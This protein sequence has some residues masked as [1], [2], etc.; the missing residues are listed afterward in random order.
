MKKRVAI[1]L[2]A[3]CMTVFC[4]GCESK[5]PYDD[6]Y[7]SDEKIAMEDQFEAQKEED[8]K[9][10]DG[11]YQYTADA[12][13]GAK[14]IWQYDAKEGESITLAYTLYEY[15]GKGKLVLVQPD[16]TVMKLAASASYSNGEGGVTSDNNITTVEGLYKLKLVGVKTPKISITL[17]FSQGSWEAHSA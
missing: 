4:I 13:S 5:K 1:A 15:K 8:S 12:F 6:I 7:D 2:L 9:L 10:E 11:S 3:L 14:T 16:Q 17:K